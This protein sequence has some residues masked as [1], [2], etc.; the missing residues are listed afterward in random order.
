MVTVPTYK[1]N[2]VASRP[3]DTTRATGPG[4]EAYGASVGKALQGLGNAVGNT[5]PVVQQFVDQRAE[6]KVREADI[7]ASTMIRDE[8]RGEQGLYRHQGSA[9][10]DNAPAYLKRIEDRVKA[11]SESGKNGL[12]QRMLQDT[13]QRRLESARNEIQGETLR[14][15]EFAH[16]AAASART[17]NAVADAS[18]YD[19]DTP[20]YKTA[21]STL[22]AASDDY[23]VAQGLGDPDSLSAA[24]RQRMSEVSTNIA[25]R[26]VLKKDYAKAGA[27]IEQQLAAGN[28]DPARATSLQ[29]HLQDIAEQT[30]LETLVEGET[31]FTLAV[32]ETMN[33]ATPE[34]VAAVVGKESSGRAGV[35]GPDNH[36]GENAAGLMQVLPSTG[37][38]TAKRLGIAWKPELMTGRTP[39]AAAYQKK[40]GKGY[41]DGLL[42]DFGGNT[43]LALAAY[44]AGPGRL[45]GYKDKN[46]TY[47]K[48]WLET[49]GDPRTGAIT[50]QQFIAKIPFDETKD[51]VAKITAR[52]GG[53]IRTPLPQTVRTADEVETWVEQFPATER[54]KARSAAYAVVN[55]NKAAD[56]DKEEK[57]YD[58]AISYAE[59]ATSTSQIPKSVWVALKPQQRISLTGHI[60]GNAT[61]EKVQTDMA[62]YGDLMTLYTANPKAF[63]ATDFE[64]DSKLSRSDQ[65]A[66]IDLRARVR[67]GSEKPATRTSAETTNRIAE[68][69]KPNGMKG[70]EASRFKGA[71]F[72]AVATAEE[73]GKPLDEKSIMDMASRLAVETALTPGFLGMKRTAPLYTLTPGLD[74]PG[75]ARFNDV[76][77]AVRDQIVYGYRKA[78]GGKSPTQGQVVDAF[79]SL[80]AQGK[81]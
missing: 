16:K 58:T 27:Y 8:L 71:V 17:I 67:A 59:N 78:N 39:E 14:Q 54:A 26:L 29:Q 53:S 37:A 64:S 5:V 56:R 48:G 62:H 46:G 18:V 40:I 74:K 63:A 81:L 47:H 34:L 22:S 2:S 51:Y 35:V 31:P 69:V 79:I 36:T 49:I 32:P 60:N 4:A 55:R 20:E 70:Q 21:I 72:R 75:T 15:S 11:L 61:G 24:R 65:K 6:T 13:L 1:P 7:A 42:K 9:F 66:F 33:G 38:E 76:P 80:K 45:T 43:V 30:E 77:V 68:M 57:L 12:E 50:A 28:I 10:V 23:M 41:L 73:N 44:N 19:P 52:L 25:S 3:T